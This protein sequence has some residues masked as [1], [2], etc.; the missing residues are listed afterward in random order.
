ME[1]RPFLQLIA[2]VLTPNARVSTPLDKKLEVE[3]TAVFR[4]HLISKSDEDR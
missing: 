2:L 4:R 3:K 1:T